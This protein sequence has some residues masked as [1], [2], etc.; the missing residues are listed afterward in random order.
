MTGV[1][2]ASFTSDELRAAAR[3]DG[4]VAVPAF[5]PGWAPEE[6]GIADA[7]CLRVLLARGLAEVAESGDGPRVVLTG[8]AR[9][10]LGPLLHP[11]A[12]VEAVREA[13][14]GRCLVGAE[15]TDGVVLA[16]QTLPRVWR[17][18]STT[19]P[20]GYALLPG[21]SAWLDELEVAAEASGPRTLAEL[22]PLVRAHV[23]VRTVR[24]LRPQVRTAGAVSWLDAGPAGVWLVHPNEEEPERES[25]PVLPTDPAAVRAAV[26]D[27]F[28]ETL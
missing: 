28:K 3:L 23:T 16:D 11:Y 26:T 4:G 9:H 20:V 6:V 21:I 24:C 5:T 17:L 10:A 8:A 19:E 7:V 13:A 27:L 2:P 14:T 15:S 18:C 1:L 25:F 12:L 22:R